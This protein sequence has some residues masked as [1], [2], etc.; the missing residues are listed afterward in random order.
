V[1]KL[2]R[3]V[4]VAAIVVALLACAP[5]KS[6]PG[7]SS[8]SFGNAHP[9][10]QE[11]YSLVNNERAAHGLGPLNWND[12]LGQLAQDWSQHMAATGSMAH[13][14]LQA[15]LNSGFDGFSALAE[16]VFSGGCGMSAGQIHQAW[17]NSPGHRANILGDFSA[18][19]IGVACNGGAL[20]ATEDFGR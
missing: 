8:I 3:T 19:G 17:M 2:L 12:Q 1:R 4:P 20:Y 13:Q 14:N 16:N 6:G 10:A 18:I 7:G 9:Q 5:V 15:I 11:L